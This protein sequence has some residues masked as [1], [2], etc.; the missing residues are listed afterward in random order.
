MKQHTTSMDFGDD[1]IQFVERRK[2]NWR[3]IFAGSVATLGIQAWFLYLGS[4]LGL[5]SFYADQASTFSDASIWG[6]I[7]FLLVTAL[8]STAVGAWICGH[9]ANLYSSEDALMHGGVTWALSA[10]LIAL[11]LAV[12]FGLSSSLIQSGAAKAQ[13]SSGLSGEDKGAEAAGSLAYDR[14]N[15][16]KFADFVGQEAKSFASKQGVPVNVSVDNNQNKSGKDSKA[17]RVDS[18][19]IENDY[20]LQRFVMTQTGLDQDTAKNFLK[21]HEE[22]LA[23]AAAE[24][25][26]LW[27]MAHARD[28]AKAENARRD[29]AHFAWTMTALGLLT[30]GTAMC[31][32]YMGWRQRYGNIHDDEIPPED[33]GAPPV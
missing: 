18:R 1:D 11:G 5:S 26:R 16:P 31:A 33:L 25:Q 21:D 2:I 20:E 12:G 15:D 29:A 7:V 17:K 28:V 22:Q 13:V 10:L 3:A 14:L 23:Q 27:E 19:N 32:S 30:L 9:W 8:I 24:S 4:A 6:P